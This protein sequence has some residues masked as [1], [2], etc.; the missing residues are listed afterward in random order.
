INGN[1]FSTVIED[2]WILIASSSKTTSLPE[3]QTTS[4]LTLQ[5]NMILA[6]SVYADGSISSIRINATG[7]ST[8]GVDPIL[9]ITTSDSSVLANLRANRTLTTGVMGGINEWSGADQGRADGS[10]ASSTGVLA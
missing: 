6:P 9:D 3:L 1:R 2:G 4:G 7:V 10:C 8:S 5:S